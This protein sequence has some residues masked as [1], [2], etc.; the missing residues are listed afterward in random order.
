[1]GRRR[2]AVGQEA[3]IEAVLI[4]D[5]KRSAS[6]IV[7]DLCREHGLASPPLDRLV[8]LSNVADLFLEDDPDFAT[9]NDYANLVKTYQFWN[10]H[11]LVDG[12]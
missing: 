10:L 3:V 1:M 11:S 5:L 9:A 8:H 12:E 6:L 7:Y 2:R 4:H